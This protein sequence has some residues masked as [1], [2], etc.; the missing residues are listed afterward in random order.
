MYCD[1]EESQLKYLRIILFLFE[2]ISGLHIK[3]RK[4]LIFPI[5]EVARIQQLTEISVEK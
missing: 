3:G 2:A 4:S 1:A 5:N